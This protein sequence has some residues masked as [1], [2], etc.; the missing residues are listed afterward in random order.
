MFSTYHLK[1]DTVRLFIDEIARR[2]L[3]W[4]H[5]YPSILHHLCRLAQQA[6]LPQVECVKYV[7]TGGENLLPSYVETIKKTFPNAMVRT[8]YGLGEAVSNISQTKEGEWMVDEDFAVTELFEIQE[9][10]PYP[11]RHNPQDLLA[12]A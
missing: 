9:I 6:G 10:T 4:L 1:P 12:A 8:H 7:T 2:K 5:G 3:T 11:A